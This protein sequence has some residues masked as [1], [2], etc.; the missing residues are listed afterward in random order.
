MLSMVLATL[1]ASILR[2][3]KIYPLGVGRNTLIYLSAFLVRLSR[4]P[5]LKSNQLLLEC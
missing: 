4:W 3:T 2:R 5:P 1:N